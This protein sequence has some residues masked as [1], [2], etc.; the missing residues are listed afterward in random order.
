MSDCP[1]QARSILRASYSALLVVGLAG[2]SETLVA[3]APRDSATALPGVVISA[4]KSADGYIERHSD[5]GMGFP[6]ELR[7]VPQSVHVISSRMLRE[8]RPV[9]LAEI[10]R[11]TG[12]VSASRNSVE[13]FRSFKLRG[14][15][16][17][18][19]FTDGIRNTGSLNIQAEGLAT[20]DRVEILR[21]PGSAVFGLGAPGGVVNL[22]TKKPLAERRAEFTMSAGNFGYVQPEIDLT[23]PVDAKG[24]LRYRLIGSYQQRDSYIDFVS[25][26][27]LQV[28][29]SVEYS[30]RDNVILRY[31][32]DVRRNEQLR[33]I[34]HPFV[35]T[36]SRTDEIRLPRSLF[37]GEPGQGATKNDGEQHTLLLERTTG[38]VGR[39]RLFVRINDNRFLQPSVAP[40]VQ[41][42]DGRTLTRRFNLFDE[43]ENER[44]LGGQIVRQRTL[45]RTTHTVSL[46]ADVATWWYTSEF[47]RGA[48]DPLDLVNPV[49]G[50]QP[51]GLFVLADSRDEFVQGGLSVQDAISIGPRLTVL[52]GGRLSRLTQQTEDRSSSTT[53]ESEHTQFSPRL[54]AAFEVSTGIVP[55]VSLSQSFIARPS[56]GFVRSPDGSPFEPERGSQMEAGI[57]F[58]LGGRL[59][60]TLAA[61]EITRSNVPTPDPDD[62]ALR[63]LTGE[64]RSRGIEFLGSWEPTDR[65]ALFG[66]YAYTDA[67]VTRDET[68]ATGAR[69]DNVPFNSGR[70]W[71]RW[72]QLVRQRYIFGATAG[73]SYASD[74]RPGIGNPLRVPSYTVV[75]AGLFVDASKVSVQL[76]VQ[77]L[78]DDFYFVRGA[79]GGNGVIP[80]DARRIMTTV[81]WRPW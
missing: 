62:P 69:L 75:D 56:F 16:I 71:G 72:S 53:T 6:T 59:M 70:L 26:Q 24:R 13:V 79:F 23:G 33:Y 41:S 12:G 73:V 1:V 80:G 19:A 3:Q 15:D 31:Q 60:T 7:R 37:T 68:F 66:S 57:K 10:V 63:I 30:L 40:N 20:V 39:D 64:Q 9:S 78:T 34:S 29:P 52:A 65:I 17:G 5:V 46:G 36:V 22:V 11:N 44:V 21:G 45:G 77:N 4:G 8:Q 81:R 49:Y 32:L 58:D 50:A 61:F 25:P 43:A 74:V 47:T 27:A 35:G 54:G 55:F 51:S 28:A 18:E 76:T 48:I 14:F 2:A 42:A 67:V 38:S